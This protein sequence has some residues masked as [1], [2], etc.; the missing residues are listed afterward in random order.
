[1]SFASLLFM[2]LRYVSQSI[3]FDL[4][5]AIAG[6]PITPS[7][8]A[9]ANPAAVTSRRPY[10]VSLR[11]IVLLL[12]DAAIAGVDCVQQ[13]GGATRVERD[14]FFRIFQRAAGRLNERGCE[15]AAR[16]GTCT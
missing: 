13:L 9:A 6:W 12:V 7:V 15:L 10:E 1:M 3:P 11:V 14:T 4:A 2:Q 5:S 8:S 16:L